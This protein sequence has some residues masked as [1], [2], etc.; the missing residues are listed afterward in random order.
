MA[1]SSSSSLS[2]AFSSCDLRS[3]STSNCNVLRLAS[4]SSLMPSAS[5]FALLPSYQYFRNRG[6]AMSTPREIERF[7]GHQDEFQW[8]GHL[9]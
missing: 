9:D 7:G 1:L 6:V 5:S 4:L 2:T 3:W 8:A